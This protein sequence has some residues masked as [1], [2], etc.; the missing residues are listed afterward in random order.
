VTQDVPD[1][2]LAISRVPQTNKDGWAARRKAKKRD[3]G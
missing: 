3:S 2:A 1:G